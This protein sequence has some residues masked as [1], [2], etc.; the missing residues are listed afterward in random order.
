MK[1]LQKHFYIL[2]E[3]SHESRQ[4]WFT[5]SNY[6]R[7]AAADLKVGISAAC[8]FGSRPWQQVPRLGNVAEHYNAQTLPAWFAPALL[9]DPEAW[10]NRLTGPGPLLLTGMRGC[11][12][13]MLLRSLE[14]PARIAPQKN[15]NSNI[16]QRRVASEPYLGI[17][18][19]CA[20]LHVNPG[21]D[22]LAHPLPR[23]FLAFCLEILRNIQISESQNIGKVN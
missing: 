23:L 2:Q 20:A 21:S 9:Y 16:V 12:K 18:A 6:R 3:L 5:K 7:A 10:A 22:T 8:N 15:E 4:T 11:G 14:W 17:F 1:K 13:T 19:S